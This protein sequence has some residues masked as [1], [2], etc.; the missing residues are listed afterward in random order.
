MLSS[1]QPLPLQLATIISMLSRLRMSRRVHATSQRAHFPSLLYFHGSFSYT[2]LLLLLIS[3]WIKP[4]GLFPSNSTV[5]ADHIRIQHLGLLGREV[6]T[7]NATYTGQ[8]KHGRKLTDKHVS[9]GV[10]THDPSVLAGPN[11][12]YL[13]PCGH[14]DRPL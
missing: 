7:S 10:R 9:S 4:S 6:S 13:Q 8:N 12:S 3:G 5:A 11:I 14:Y 1:L 2:F